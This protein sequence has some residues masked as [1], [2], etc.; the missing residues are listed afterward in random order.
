M[1]KGR[2]REFDLNLALDRALRLFWE[3]GYEATSLSQLTRA[4][5][6]S[7]PSLYAAFGNKKSLFF[8]ALD[9]YTEHR[10]AYIHDALAQPS[11]RQV[12]ERLLLGAADAL[13]SPDLPHGCLLIRGALTCTRADA[14][15][16][17]ELRARRAAFATAIR[18]RF[19]R[20][21]GDLPRAVRP[22]DLVAFVGAIISGMAVQAAGGAS[23]AAL[24]AVAV[25]AS[26]AWPN[27][28]DAPRSRGLLRP[29]GRAI[30]QLS[31]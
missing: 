26:R 21:R 1:R 30:L 17:R 3:R 11:A 2:P 6:I 8:R 10:A 31:H 28:A 19:A 13:T 20:A 24:R 22:E 25:T 27:G 29:R 15:I 12:F 16:S 5:G 4:M 14:A 7:R 18:R 23:R 9:R